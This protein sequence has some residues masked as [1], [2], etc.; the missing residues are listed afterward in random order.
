MNTNDVIEW[1]T[2]EQITTASDWNDQRNI[3]FLTD[4]VFFKV[5]RDRTES[6]E[7][8]IGDHTD[9]LEEIFNW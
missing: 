9:E 2:A 7:K 3:P 1:F 8:P 4:K 6:V 5:V